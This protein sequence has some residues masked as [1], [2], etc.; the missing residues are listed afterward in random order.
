MDKI[1]YI[2][3]DNQRIAPLRP[4]PRI[5]SVGREATPRD[6]SSP[7]GIVDRVTISP[8]G[9]QKAEQF[10]RTRNTDAPLEARPRPLLTYGPGT[11]R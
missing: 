9:R 1:P 10:A 8:E 4:T 5:V 11:W 7:F 2:I 3:V 6:A